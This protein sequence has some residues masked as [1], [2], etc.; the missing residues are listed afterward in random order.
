MIK[1]SE[2]YS[3]LSSRKQ[4]S[5]IRSLMIEQAPCTLDFGGVKSM[6]YGYAD[7][8]IAVL[9]KTK[10]ADWFR[11]NV[12]IINLDCHI[13]QVIL[14]CISNRCGPECNF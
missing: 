9:V 4:A 5:D 13:K 2:Y 11:K 10:G 7:E 6:S 14:E 8:L 3:D 12:T 1:L